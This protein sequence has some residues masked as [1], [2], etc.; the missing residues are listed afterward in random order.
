MYIFCM[1]KEGTEEAAAVAAFAV[2]GLIVKI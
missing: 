2:F 1:V